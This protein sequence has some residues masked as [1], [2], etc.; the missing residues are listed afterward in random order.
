MLISALLCFDERLGWVYTVRPCTCCIPNLPCSNPYTMK[1]RCFYLF[2][3][4]LVAHGAFAQYL[5]FQGKLFDADG[6]PV[7]GTRDFVFS[8][9]DGGVTWV[10]SHPGV[11]IF[12]GV[13]A[14]VLGSV[15]EPLP[16]NL[17]ENSVSHTL[18]IEID[19]ALLD[20]VMLYR[21]IET[22]PKVP[23]EL[24]DGVDWS[25]IQNKPVDPDEDPTNELQ[26][27]SLRNDTLFLSGSNFIALDALLPLV[28]LAGVPVGTILP[29]GGSSAPPGYLPCDGRVVSRIDYPQLFVAIATAWGGDGNP[30]FHLPDLRGRFLRGWDNGEGNDPDIADRFTLYPKGSM[31]DAVGSYQNDQLGN[32]KHDARFKAGAEPSTG[33]A[34]SRHN[35]AAGTGANAPT[36]IADLHI[37]EAGGKETRPKNAYVNFIIK[38]Q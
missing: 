8:I 3:F 2:V 27:L 23:D 1:Y 11:E 31:G 15:S 17:F 9:S 30:N 33:G 12:A 13:Y 14:V 35:A 5:P 26:T 29:Y 20:E 38:A 7:S 19:G 18:R 10:E 4:L 36:W 22:D 32:H 16:D 28:Q 34:R 24:K 6:Q 37:I 21:P 25:E